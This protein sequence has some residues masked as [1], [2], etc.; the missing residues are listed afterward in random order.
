MNA[1]LAAGGVNSSSIDYSMISDSARVIQNGLRIATC[2]IRCAA[3]RACCVHVARRTGLHGGISLG[4]TPVG[5]TSKLLGRHSSRMCSSCRYYEF[6]RRFAA[7]TSAIRLHRAFHQ[8]MWDKYEATCR[9]VCVLKTCSS[10][11]HLSASYRL[12]EAWSQ[13]FQTL[14]A[15]LLTAFSCRRCCMC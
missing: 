13:H 11:C 4:N 8:R 10:V 2:M 5:S 7:V 1:C 15:C 12:R 6:Q 3:W 14:C 9:Q